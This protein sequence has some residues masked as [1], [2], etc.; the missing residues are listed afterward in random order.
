LIVLM[1]PPMLWARTVPARKALESLSERVHHRSRR[2]TNRHRAPG[3][4]RSM[5]L[6]RSRINL[7]GLEPVV[8]T[9]RKLQGSIGCATS[10]SSMR[11]INDRW[12]TFTRAHND[13][14]SIVS[15]GYE[16][17]TAPKTTESDGLRALATVSDVVVR[18]GSM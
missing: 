14:L 8:L 3:R 16:H 2:N 15:R 4:W 1:S 5:L 7:G 9:P 6:R 10:A 11:R 18:D 13:Q 17:W 12:G